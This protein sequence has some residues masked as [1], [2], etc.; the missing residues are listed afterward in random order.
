MAPMKTA[1][2]L[3]AALVIAAAGEADQTI[4]LGNGC[5]TDRDCGAG[6]Y[7]SRCLRDLSPSKCI[8]STA[9]NLFQI[10]VMLMM[11]MMI[12]EPS[13]QGGQMSPIGLARYL[14]RAGPG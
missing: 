14:V 1:L 8:R 7:C 3:A 12:D 9:T 11:I 13:C 5:K 4:L 10:V 2:L 6:E